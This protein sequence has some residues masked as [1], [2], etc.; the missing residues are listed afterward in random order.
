MPPYFNMTRF[1]G[2]LAPHSATR[3]EVVSKPEVSEPPQM[4]LFN[5]E[6]DENT[7]ETTTP[8]K[9]SWS[10]LLARVFKI[11]VSVCPQCNGQMKIID[12]VTKNAT[13]QSVLSGLAESRPRDGPAATAQLAIF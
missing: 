8:A 13:I 7:A 6:K 1:Y 11:D 2:V 12:A 5:S 9:Q 3:K 4:L 10:K